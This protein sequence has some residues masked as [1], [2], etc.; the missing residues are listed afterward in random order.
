VP[1]TARI[2]KPTLWPARV[3]AT[4]EAGRTWVMAH[5]QAIQAIRVLADRL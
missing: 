5:L 1:S 4:K 3:G 2:R